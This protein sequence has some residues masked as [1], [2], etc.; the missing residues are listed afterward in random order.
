MVNLAQQW[1]KAFQPNINIQYP[2]CTY[3]YLEVDDDVKSGFWIKRGGGTWFT[4]CQQKNLIRLKAVSNILHTQLCLEEWTWKRLAKQTTN[5]SGRTWLVRKVIY[6]ATVFHNQE[7]PISA[8]RIWERLKAVINIQVFR[9]FISHLQK[10]IQI[11]ELT[12]ISFSTSF[13]HLW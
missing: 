9:M 12:P 10:E 2:S 1:K 7:N 5:M 13:A 4:I 11:S 6:T 8:L 3:K